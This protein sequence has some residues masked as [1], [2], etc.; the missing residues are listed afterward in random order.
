[1][2]DSVRNEIKRVARILKRNKMDLVPRFER[3]CLLELV[4]VAPNSEGQITTVGEMVLAS[5]FD[6]KAAA[7]RLVSSMFDQIQKPA[8]IA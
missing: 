6:G 7:N 4:A 8:L 5:G 2:N 3:D 1:M